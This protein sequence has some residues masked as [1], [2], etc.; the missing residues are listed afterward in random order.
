MPRSG[1]VSHQKIISF[2]PSREEFRA[3][4]GAV[5]RSTTIGS[6]LGVLPGAGA[7]ISSFSAYAFEKQI[8]K[9]PDKF[10]TG[11]IEGVAARQDRGTSPSIPSSFEACDLLVAR[12]Q[13]KQ[14]R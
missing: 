6:V 14:R 3:S 7:V 9:H 12:S 4:V 10:G 13:P 5:L 2:M 11:V 8:S 1:E